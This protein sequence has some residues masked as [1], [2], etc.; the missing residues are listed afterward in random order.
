MVELVGY[1]SP[2]I[3]L[4]ADPVSHRHPQVGV[5]GGIGICIG[6][7]VHRFP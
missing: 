1:Q 3:V 5:V 6:L 7:G 4:R 2:S